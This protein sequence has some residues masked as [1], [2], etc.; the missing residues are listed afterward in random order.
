MAF[1]TEVN[2]C[3][4]L[5]FINSNKPVNLL[6][7]SVDSSVVCPVVLIGTVSNIKGKRLKDVRVEIKSKDRIGFTDKKGKYKFDFEHVKG[8]SV[9]VLFSKLGFKDKSITVP[10]IEGPRVTIFYFGD[11]DSI[12]RP[13]APQVKNTYEFSLDVKMEKL[14]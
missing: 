3:K 5:E 7:S 14:D 13:V 1:K 2:E 10:W 4:E 12:S 6:Q 8:D 9:S 11:M